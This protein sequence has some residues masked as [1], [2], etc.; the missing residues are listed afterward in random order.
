MKSTKSTLTTIGVAAALALGGIAV[1]QTSGESTTNANDM[2]SSATMQNSGSS[3][4]GGS[5]AQSSSSDTSVLG[6]GG[7]T[8][9]SSDSSTAATSDMSASSGSGPVA[10]VDRN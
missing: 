4:L 7:S 2:S 9:M 10:Q 8:P 6:A 1:A 3:D 5:N